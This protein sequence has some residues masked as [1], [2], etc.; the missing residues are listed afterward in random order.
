MGRMNALPKKYTGRMKSCLSEFPDEILQEIISHLSITEAAATS[1]L[2]ARWRH[3]WKTVDY[4]I[5]DIALPHL[6]SKHATSFEQ[7]R[8]FSLASAILDQHHGSTIHELRIG[9][10][11][12]CFGISVDMV[13]F[14]CC[15]INTAFQ[16]RVRKL[17]IDLPVTIR[18]PINSNLLPSNFTSLVSLKLRG[19]IYVLSHTLIDYFLSNCP[20]LQELYV[21]RL[22]GLENLIIC[23]PNLKHFTFSHSYVDYLEISAPKLVSF[24]FRHDSK[25]LICFKM[26]PSLKHVSLEGCT[27]YANLQS[28]NIKDTLS[29]LDSLALTLCYSL[30]ITRSRPI[31]NFPM[32]KNLK[33]LKLSKFYYTDF[34][35]MLIP[36][37]QVSPGLLKLSL[38]NFRKSFDRRK[39]AL[40]CFAMCSHRHQC[41][42]VVEI[43]GFQG[44]N[45][46]IE[47]ACYLTCFA[48][49]SI[50]KI[51]VHADSSKGLLQ[52]RRR[53]PSAVALVLSS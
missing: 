18:N 14:F 49:A 27:S 10:P 36:L 42:E 19:F 5:F 53:L 34:G 9:F 21:H 23:A 8:I 22:I 31:T 4:P 26:V 51:I 29:Q 2:A 17:V 41:L 33:Q 30:N 1:V 40:N 38:I 3:L 11:N 16:R 44:L 12:S 50:K 45:E 47:F 37:L 15:W 48:A 46:E 13:P 39:S 52:F 32:L 24:E 43:V 7:Q 35:Y 25:P 6:I 20:F 28:K